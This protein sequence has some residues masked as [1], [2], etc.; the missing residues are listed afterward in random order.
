MKKKGM[1]FS[2][3]MVGM[4]IGL[5]TLPSASAWSGVWYNAIFTPNYGDV[6]TVC[7]KYPEG[8]KSKITR[9]C[10][11]YCNGAPGRACMHFKLQTD[12]AWTS[13]GEVAG[14]R[15]SKWTVPPMAAD[16]SMFRVT[17]T[18]HIKWYAEVSSVNNYGIEQ[19]HAKL[20]VMANVIDTSANPWHYEL[21]Y[22]PETIICDQWVGYSDSWSS[23]NKEGDYKVAIELPLERGHTYKFESKLV[24]HACV[25][26]PS[27]SSGHSSYAMIDVAEDNN[28]GRVACLTSI[29]I[30]GLIP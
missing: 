11:P 16:I 6:E 19:A 26:S 14:L 9:Y 28:D 27:G 12:G 23:G 8:D 1:I 22:W 18:W 2:I 24:G 21:D 7:D 30:E 3:L 17:F 15:C 5:S 25:T 10:E 29:N 20:S 4:L 13:E